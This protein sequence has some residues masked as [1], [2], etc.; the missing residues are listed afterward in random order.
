MNL[1]CVFR[2]CFP[3][4]T[5]DKQKKNRNTCTIILSMYI[6]IYMDLEQKSF[7]DMSARI[8]LQN[9]LLVRLW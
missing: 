4:K 8:C 5:T 7:H 6:Y 9:G 1:F 2:E 3:Q